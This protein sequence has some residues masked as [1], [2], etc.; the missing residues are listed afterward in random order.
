VFRDI[1]YIP[2]FNPIQEA[3]ELKGNSNYVVLISHI[4][5]QGKM[6]LSD[7]MERFL[8]FS[9]MN[10]HIN[11]FSDN[12]SILTL[13]INSYTIL[14]PEILKTILKFPKIHINAVNDDKETALD[15][16]IKQLKHQYLHHIRYK[17]RARKLAF[18]SLL[19]SHHAA[20]HD[21][22]ALYQFLSQTYKQ[23]ESLF[24]QSELIDLNSFYKENF[25]NLL[26]CFQ[27]FCN[28][29]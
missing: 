10:D 28:Q 21:F 4:V 23:S 24:N 27:E 16:L 26:I 25:S 18:L 9:E 5:D 7:A 13:A 12:E 11:D 15:I 14:K 1:F 20:I 6:S 3:F 2:N 19:L 17:T 29:L 8:N 22:R